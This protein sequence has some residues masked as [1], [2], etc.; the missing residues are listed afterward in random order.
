MSL[1]RMRHMQM[2]LLSGAL[3]A[4]PELEALLRSGAVIVD[5]A[6]LARASV[7]PHQ[8]GQIFCV[9]VGVTE[10]P[11]SADWSA[12]DERYQWFGRK[13]QSVTSGAHLFTL[14]V[15]TWRSAVVGLYEAV[16]AG[17][18]ML[19]DS[20]D[21]DRWPWARG[22]KPLAAIAPQLATRVDGQIGPQSGLPARVSDPDARA[23]LYAAIADSPPPPGPRT[24]EQRVQEL[25]WFDLSGDILH[26][27]AEL[28]REAKRG[29]VL[30]RAR[31]IGGWTD[32]E[33]AARAW[34]TGSGTTSHIEHLLLR[35]LQLEESSTTHLTRAFGSSPYELTDAGRAH[36]GDFGEPYRT[37]AHQGRAGDDI[38]ERLVDIAN[39]EQSTRRHMEVQD[40]VADALIV[41]GITPLGPGAL[42]PR[43]DLGF[44]HDGAH[45]VIEV[46]TGAPATTQQARLGVGQ[47][48][49][50][51]HVLRERGV[52][53]VRPVLCVETALPEPWPDL[54]KALAVRVIRADDLGG[55][56]G[57]LLT[58]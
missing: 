18:D 23:A 30:A 32:E 37:G 6:G 46:K 4:A 41:R 56:L 28:G 17:A 43:F 24:L 11:V 54:T 8:S 40:R 49:E 3:S 16:S 26:A 39:L 12:F 14:A 33:L 58:S 7:T 10:D 57:A 50:Y 55:T 44:V 35:A 48:L 1:A 51:C 21:P 47:V 5:D 22:G 20:P 2:P 53:A 36:I 25:E 34:F 29:T 42:D 9:A 45:Y 19:P 27:V 15:G 13:P 38:P 52:V 31:E